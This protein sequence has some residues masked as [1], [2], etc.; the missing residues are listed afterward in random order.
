[1]NDHE[2]IELYF[3]RNEEAIQRTSEKY[4]AYCF[5][6]AQRIV[7]LHE[8]AEE[9]VN[10]TYLAAWNSMPPKRPDILRLFL[11]KI[12]RSKAINRWK[13]RHAKKRGSDEVTLVLEELEECVGTN[14]TPEGEVLANELAATIDGF[15]RSLSAKER[16]IFLRRYFYTEPIRRIAETEGVSENY[17]SV[18]L[19]RIRKSLKEYLLKEGFVA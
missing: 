4:G 6:V 3:A 19:H 9:C 15:L 5:T 8:D 12:T 1:M 17:A 14:A 7:S 16:T 18:I 2:I 10:D 11:A 13:A